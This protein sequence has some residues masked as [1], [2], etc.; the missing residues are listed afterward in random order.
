M[1]NDIVN[2]RVSYSVN[3]ILARRTKNEGQSNWAIGGTA[4]NWGEGP[5]SEPPLHV[6]D[7]DPCLIQSYFGSNEI[8]NGI[9]FRLPALARRTSVSDDI[10]TDGQTTLRSHVSQ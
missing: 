2:N 8:P 10:H 5:T 1:C 6:G 4:A 3:V 7:R 9:S